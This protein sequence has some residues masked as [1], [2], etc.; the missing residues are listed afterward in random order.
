MLNEFL[1]YNFFIKNKYY[2][3]YL[4][5][6]KKIIN[7]NRTYDSSLHENHHILPDAF[8]GAIMLPYTF[9]EHYVAHLL[10]TKFTINKDKH[11]MTFALHTFFH[12][13]RNRKLGIKHSSVTYQIHKRNFIKTCMETRGGNNHSTSDKK[14]Y[15][16]KNIVTNDVFE[17]TRID[18]LSHTNDLNNYDLNA[19]I[20][21]YKNNVH[22]KTKGWSIYNDSLEIFTDEIPKKFNNNVN[23]KKTCE[24]CKKIVSLGNYSRWH[25]SNCKKV[26]PKGHLNRTAQVASIKPKLL[27][28]S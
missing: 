4:N 11:K 2:Y 3:W 10:L 23:S 14:I 8:G 15:K 7:E 9:K 18:L 22:W 5:L 24:H 17:G 16:F 13:D 19:L 1:S 12:F 26:D 21:A 28:T 20:R 25:G 27:N 6:A